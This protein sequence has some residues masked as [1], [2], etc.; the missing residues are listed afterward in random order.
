MA[1]KTITESTR[2]LERA[3]SSE[4]K[5]VANNPEGLN[6][7]CKLCLVSGACS[8]KRFMS[9]KDCAFGNDDGV[10]KRLKMIELMGVNHE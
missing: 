4:L 2:I 6:I 10:I 8:A 7:I 9:C 1:C 5:R 3:I